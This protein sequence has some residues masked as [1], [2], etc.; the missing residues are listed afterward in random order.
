[1][2]KQGG[3]KAKE[4]KGKEGRTR[5]G[6]ERTRRDMGRKVRP[7]WWSVSAACR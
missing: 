7:P 2:E 4:R 1:M 3:N 6:K 5:K